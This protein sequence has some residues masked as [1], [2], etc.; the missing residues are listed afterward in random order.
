MALMQ[1]SEP[2]QSSAPHQQRL[3]FGS[4]AFQN[5][6][7]LLPIVDIFGQRGF[8]ADRLCPRGPAGL[9]LQGWKIR[10]FMQP[11]SH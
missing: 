7:H 9:A 5:V 1:I 11:S 8:L 4:N 3:Q 10:T 6:Q 2:G